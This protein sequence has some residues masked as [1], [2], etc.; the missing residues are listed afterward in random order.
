MSAFQQP[1]G[2]PV[3]FDRRCPACG[4][5]DTASL[6]A[7]HEHGTSRSTGL[8]AGLVGDRLG[9]GGAAGVS[10]N[11]HCR[12][13][14]RDGASG[15]PPP[16]GEHRHGRPAAGLGDRLL[17]AGQASPARSRTPE[18]GGRLVRVILRAALVT[19]IVVGTGGHRADAET[20]DISDRD[21]RQW[22]DQQKQQRL[23][24]I[25][26]K[27][28][29]I[30]DLRKQVSAL[31]Q[32]SLL[33]AKKQMI[34]ASG[35]PDVQ[36]MNERLLAGKWFQYSPSVNPQGPIAADCNQRRHDLAKKVVAWVS[37][38]GPLT[39]QMAAMVD[40]KSDG[41]GY[42]HHPKLGMTRDQLDVFGRFQP[43]SQTSVQGGQVADVGIWYSVTVN[44]AAF[45]YRFTFIDNVLSSLDEEAR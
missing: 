11:R 39:D 44:N 6:R 5:D 42:G 10:V 3:P 1:P 19:M 45:Y 13:R 36:V 30:A 32:E 7:I 12:A 35:G 31:A 4:S 21:A 25:K 24:E 18:Q 38:H 14:V 41:D 20:A 9:V 34:A 2:Q 43:Q 23:A 15:S 22:I 26:A 37:G 27:E 28:K 17:D 33:E 8:V 16:E 40:G 29:E